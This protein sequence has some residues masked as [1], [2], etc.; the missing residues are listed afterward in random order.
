[1]DENTAKFAE[2]AQD[3]QNEQRNDTSFSKTDFCSCEI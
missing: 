3:E 1:M 2:G